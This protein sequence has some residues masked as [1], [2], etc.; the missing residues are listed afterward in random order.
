MASDPSFVPVPQAV[1][2]Y[3]ALGDESRLRLLLQLRERGE[4]DVTTLCQA[5]GQ[6]QTV[7]SHHLSLLRLARLV[8]FRRDGKRNVYRIS[9]PLVADFLQQVG[10]P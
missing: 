10:M 1:Q 3:R 8:T 2:V 4:A 9:S 6:S 7:V 5:V